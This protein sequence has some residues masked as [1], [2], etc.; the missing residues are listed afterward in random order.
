MFVILYKASCASSNNV[1][2]YFL[3]SDAVLAFRNN[4]VQLISEH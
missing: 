4:L 2:G 1:A 3:F